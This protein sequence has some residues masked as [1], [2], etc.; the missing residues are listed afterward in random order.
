[1]KI[2]Y[3]KKIEYLT[4]YPHVNNHTTVNTDQRVFSLLQFRSVHA[5]FY[6]LQFMYAH[7]QSSAKITGD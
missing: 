7:Y 4:L 3:I 1:M 2:Q 6:E 5:S